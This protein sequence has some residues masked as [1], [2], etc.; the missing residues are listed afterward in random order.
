[1]SDDKITEYL[2]LAKPY[3]D[4]SEFI[5]K[6]HNIVYTPHTIMVKTTKTATA[7]NAPLDTPVLDTTIVVDTPVEKVE[8]VKKTPSEKKVSEK[9]TKTSKVVI[10][11]MV[12]F[13]MRVI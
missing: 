5:K 6:K 2:Y 8:K 1:M 4:F 12:I 3:E 11:L 13:I 7:T 9:K 10:I